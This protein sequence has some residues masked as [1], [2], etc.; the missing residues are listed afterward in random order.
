[1][2]AGDDHVDLGIGRQL[3]G[4]VDRA[5]HH[6]HIAQTIE[7]ASDLHGGGARAEDDGVAGLDERGC[8]RADAPLFVDELT[9]LLAKG[10]SVG[11]ARHQQRAAVDAAHQSLR[12][13]RLEVAADGHL[14]GD[15]V[16]REVAYEHR[17]RCSQAIKNAI[18]PL[19]ATG[20]GVRIRPTLI[21]SGDHL[22][23][24][25]HARRM[26]VKRLLRLPARPVARSS[27]REP[28]PKWSS[29]AE[30]AGASRQ[31]ACA[32]T[33]RHVSV[34]PHCLS[35]TPASRQ[36]HPALPEGPRRRPGDT[37]AAVWGPNVRLLCCGQVRYR[38]TAL[39]WLA[40]LTCAGMFVVLVMGAAVINAGSAEG[41]G[42]SWPL[43]N[44]RLVPEFTVSTAIE[45]SHRAVTGVEGLLV[46][47][48]T[49]AML[50]FWRC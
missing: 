17:A 24:I 50:G 43:C 9:R 26:A 14:R 13:E 15:Q 48:L 11:A 32:V 30:A 23:A 35:V 27:F 22:C 38:P 10:G 34:T 41:C 31:H 6:R 40:A 45:Y 7:V 39:R 16:G 1:M 36:R 20:D 5:G 4:D 49:A 25:Q 19:G 37:A 8:R 44:G 33:P 47:A 42:R 29:A 46:V 28:L 18:A 3:G 21:D 2:A 12:L